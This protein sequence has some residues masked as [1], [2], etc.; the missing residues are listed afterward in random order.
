MLR[1]TLFA[2]ALAAAALAAPAQAQEWKSQIKELRIGLLGGENTADRLKRYDGFQKL[3][4]D[5]FGIPIKLFPA[6]DYAGV[7]QAMAAGQLDISEF[8]PAAFA[9]A[10]LDC[11]CVEPVLVTSEKD[12]SVYYIAVMVVRADS[13]IKS[14]VAELRRIDPPPT[15]RLRVALGSDHAGFELKESL[16]AVLDRLEVSWEDVGTHSRESTD[17]PDYAAAVGRS[18]ARKEAE[19]GLLVCSSGV[20]MSI[21]ANKIH[22][23]RAA[24]GT[25]ADEV[26]Y[27]RKHNDANVLAIGAKYTDEPTAVAL[28]DTFLTTPFEGGRHAR[29][30]E[31]INK[32]EQEE[33]Q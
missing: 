15:T 28:L 4:G 13:G 29:R 14:I 30:I 17:Y 8:S 31:K 3:I 24:L 26:G 6:A 2:L 11:K 22:G 32:L 19:L 21:A 7:M 5:R 1:R 10:W 27:T 9:G 23:V 25:N 12:G 16:K 33:Q 18:V 20:G